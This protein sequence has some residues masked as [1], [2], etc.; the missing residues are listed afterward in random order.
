MTDDD[1]NE[2]Q[3]QHDEAVKE[4]QRRQGFFDRLT[5][6]D[7]EP[8][9]LRDLH[10]ARERADGII[11][12]EVWSSAAMIVGKDGDPDSLEPAIAIRI[13][14]RINK[15]DEHVDLHFMVTPEMGD[16][17]VEAVLTAQE[18]LIDQRY[19]L[20]AIKTKRKKK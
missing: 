3:R 6:A 7:I 1:V 2:A 10:E 14:G 19:G 8:Q 4:G 12:V 5:P 11:L 17:I 18:R 16:T 13:E 15:T 9:L 20:T